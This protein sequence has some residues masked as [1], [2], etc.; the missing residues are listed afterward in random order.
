MFA[1]GLDEVFQHIVEIFVGESMEFVIGSILD[2]MWHKDVGWIRA[3][4]FRLCL[5]GLFKFRR[6]DANSWDAAIF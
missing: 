6:C 5:G 4:R 2:R 1:S 3:Q